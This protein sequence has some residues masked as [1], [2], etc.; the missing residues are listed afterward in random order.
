MADCLDQLQ[1]GLAQ[2]HIYLSQLLAGARPQLATSSSS[3]A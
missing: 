3:N 2:P 1:L